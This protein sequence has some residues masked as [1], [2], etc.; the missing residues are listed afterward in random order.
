LKLHNISFNNLKR[1]KGKV[2]FLVMGL[3]IGISTIVTLLSI[4]ESMSR[5]IEDRLDQFG[6]NI[7]MVP[8]SRNLSLS[9]GG[10]T[11]G[12]VNLRTNEFN[13][14]DI[15][16]I[17]TIRNKENLGLVAPKILG[18]TKV[19]GY[20]PVMLMGAE[21]ETEL[22]L[23]NWWMFDG[24]PPQNSDE[25]I[26]GSE[27]AV[28]LDKKIGDTVTLQD[29]TFTVSAIL[30]PT[31]AAEDGLI[32]GD[33]HAIQQ[34]LGKEGKVSMVE[35]AAFCRDCPITEMVLQIAGKFPEAKV[36]ALKQAVMSKMQSIEM[37][38]SFSYG[39]AVLVSFI[40]SLLVFVTMM[41]SVNER[42]REIGIFRAIGFRRGHVMQIILLEAM[43]VGIIGGILG[44]ASG[45]AIAWAVMPLVITDSTFGGINISLGGIA[46]L[47]SVSL[48]LL[49]SLY[50]AQKASRLD[51]SEALRAL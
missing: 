41:G 2:L 33:L 19:S 37:F 47:L 50:P 16:R 28:T 48:S 21:L 20:G 4:T 43:V 27:A 35:I 13:E 25:L 9:Y 38:K 46:I 40:G 6:A 34:V 23:K 11:V 12:G 14:A 10:I 49:A 1:R 17:R 26:L 51:P 22:A 8:Q 39:I 15:S 3:L 30:H 7:V 44:F 36:T 42:T 29:R 32:I 24:L 18:A 31:G 5:D 45:N